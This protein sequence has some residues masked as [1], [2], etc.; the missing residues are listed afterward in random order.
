MMNS[1]IVASKQVKRM[2]G[3]AAVVATLFVTVGTLTL[4]EHYAHSGRAG[5]DYTAGNEAVQHAVPTANRHA[6][7]GWAV[8]QS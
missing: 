7:S 3:L 5:R 6:Q 8:T 2:A 1:V 4:A